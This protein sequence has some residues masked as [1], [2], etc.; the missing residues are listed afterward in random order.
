MVSGL[1]HR[2]LQRNI[3]KM[4]RVEVVFLRKNFVEVSSADATL[5]A[6]NRSPLQNVFTSTSGFRVHAKSFNVMLCVCGVFYKKRKT[7]VP[8]NVN[9]KMFSTH[10]Q[11]FLCWI[12]G[13]S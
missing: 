2:S 7:E 9:Q 8:L 6:A 1:V 12:R 11:E 3:T 10:S 4:N 13:I 5:L